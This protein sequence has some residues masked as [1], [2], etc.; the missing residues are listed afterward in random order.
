M[1]KG[2]V[3]FFMLFLFM[4]FVIALPA[5][6][7][8]ADKEV[9]FLNLTDYTGP[10]VA[11]AV[12]QTKG[13]DDYFRYVNEKGGVDGVK[14]KYIGVDT[15]YDV[16]RAVSGYKRYRKTKNLLVVNEVST[17]AAKLLLPMVNRDKVVL[18]ANAAGEFQAHIGRT[19]LWS[20]T[21]QDV[22]SAAVDWAV[23]DWKK[24]GKSGMP[25]IGLIAWD[26]DAGRVP[27][28]GG[29]QYAEN[30]GVKLLKPEFFPPGT[31]DHTIYLIRLKKADYIYIASCSDPAP[32]NI[33]RDGHRIGMRYPETTFMSDI[34]GPDWNIG[35]EAYKDELQGA[36]VTSYY[37]RGTDAVEHPLAKLL[38]PKYRK[39]P[40]SE[41]M[42]QYLG[43]M[44][45]AMAFEAA[46]KIALKDVGY[47]KI[48][49]D[50]MFTA[51]Q[52]LTGQNVYQG[53]QAKCAYSPTSRRG[54][55]AVRF[56]QVKDDVMVPITG[57]VKTP[58][59]V[60]LHK[61]D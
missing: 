32:T 33:I 37:F 28:R 3:G 47:A 4:T 15:R 10:A 59:A 44:A 34:Y 43:G 16:S 5:V 42:P 6:C 41:M 35:L 20:P 23:G 8:G 26:N 7:Y 17:P 31:S 53:I 51:Y 18:L 25:T 27:F 55:E 11:V 22:F 45:I 14:L 13:L 52:K 40:M 36:V 2:I 60:S 29:K 49:G 57:W 48:N 19:F 61:W 58:D 30:L 12:P 54:S 56:Y 50:A 38:W 21:Y 24:K 1:K 46:V 9:V 39:K